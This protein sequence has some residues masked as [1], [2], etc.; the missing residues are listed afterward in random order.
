[1]AAERD[2]DLIVMGVQGRTAIDLMVFG[3]TTHEVIRNAPCPV[4]TIRREEAV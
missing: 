4:L 1:V 3:S 2:A